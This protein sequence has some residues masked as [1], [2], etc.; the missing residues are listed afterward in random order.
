MKRTII[1][2]IRKRLGL[3]KNEK[4]QFINQKSSAVYYFTDTAIMKEW[5]G[6]TTLSNVSV[7]WMLNDECVIKKV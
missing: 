2:L 1:F 5:C 7:N 6:T 3:K 4:F